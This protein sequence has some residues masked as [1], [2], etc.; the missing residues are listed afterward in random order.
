MVRSCIP[1][2]FAASETARRTDDSVPPPI[3][4]RR[5]PDRFADGYT[6]TLTRVPREQPG[7]MKPQGAHWVGDL[8][9]RAESRV[10][11]FHPQYVGIFISAGAR[12]VK[13]LL[14]S[15]ASLL[16]HA[17][18]NAALAAFSFYPLFS[19]AGEGLRSTESIVGGRASGRRT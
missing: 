8:V 16:L 10:S 12:K 6:K 4:N 15:L 9:T 13:H 3:K 19:D 5:K 2:I 1:N 11:A 7:G 14:S 17:G 18:N